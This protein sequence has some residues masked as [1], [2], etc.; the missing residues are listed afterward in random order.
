[1]HTA[2]FFD[3]LGDPL[4]AY[5]AELEATS[6][7]ADAALG[8]LNQVSET[9]KTGTADFRQAEARLYDYSDALDTSKRSHIDFTDI[10]DR[11]TTPAVEDLTTA[12][13]ETKQG[14]ELTER[15]FE[16]LDTVVAEVADGTADAG[17]TFRDLEAPIGDAIDALGKLAKAF[18]NEMCPGRDINYKLAYNN[19]FFSAYC[20]EINKRRKK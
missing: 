13:D 14:A 18:A 20:Q 3:G 16:S 5:V 17:D 10:V 6:V 2:G 4:A 9:V 7:A 11:E 1:M 15:A 12:L 19:L 8:P